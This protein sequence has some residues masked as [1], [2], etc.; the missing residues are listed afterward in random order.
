MPMDKDTII[1]I[2]DECQCSYWEKNNIDFYPPP[3]KDG[4]QFIF[5]LCK[6]FKHII[7]SIAGWYV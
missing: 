6:H 1:S 5:R 7:I 2:C 3:S 4:K